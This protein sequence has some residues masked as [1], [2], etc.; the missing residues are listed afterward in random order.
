MVVFEEFNNVENSSVNGDVEV[1]TLANAE[2]FDKGDG[3]IMTVEDITVVEVYEALAVAEDEDEDR[4][5]NVEG[6]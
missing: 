5:I 4:N 3:D 2:E 6:N 1:K